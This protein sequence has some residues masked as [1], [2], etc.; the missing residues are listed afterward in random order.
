M[1]K[2]GWV[3]SPET[4]RKW[5]IAR[6]GKKATPETI[7]KLSSLRKGKKRPPFSEEWRKHISEGNKGRT[8][9]NKGTHQR[10]SG[11]F[12]SG[13]EHWNWKGGITP[14]D[15]LNRR[16]PEYIAWRK[17]VFERDDYRCIDCGAKSEKGNR[18]ELH[19]DHLF[20]FSTYPQLRYEL[21]N[22]I[23]RCAP[24]HRLTPTYGFRL[25]NNPTAHSYAGAILTGLIK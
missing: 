9:T 24:C 5:S 10:H 4:R 7:A 15:K 11:S 20:P 19:P 1:P 2:K 22:G 6:K 25:N 17:A 16:T 23:T 18:V 12:K 21:N 13:S 8:P 14:L 3:P